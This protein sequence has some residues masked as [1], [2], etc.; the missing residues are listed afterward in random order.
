MGNNNPVSGR[1]FD[2]K[3]SRLFVEKGTST[4]EM[5]HGEKRLL[6]FVVPQRSKNNTPFLGDLLF[7]KKALLHTFFEG[8]KAITV[9]VF[10]FPRRE[11]SPTAIDKKALHYKHLPLLTANGWQP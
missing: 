5:M 6:V 11:V 4:S 1:V 9:L 2:L 10:I 7:L 3:S 8:E